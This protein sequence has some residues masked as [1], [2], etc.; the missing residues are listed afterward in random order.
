MFYLVQVDIKPDHTRN[1]HGLWVRWNFELFIALEHQRHHGH[2]LQTNDRIARFLVVDHKSLQLTQ[3]ESLL[4]ALECCI[5]LAHVLTRLKR[6]RLQA[7][8]SEY[9]RD[10]LHE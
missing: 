1:L 10:D 9:V 7:H 2:G 6:P 8:G 5:V 3:V 4:Q